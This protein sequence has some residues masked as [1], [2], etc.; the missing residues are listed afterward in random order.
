MSERDYPVGHPAA[1]DYKGEKYIP[2]RA[3]FSF[4]Y[5]EDHPARAG[6]NS[7]AVDSPDGLRAAVREQ[8]AANAAMTAKYL[9]EATVSE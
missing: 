9:A 4:D 6:R 8:H 1:S 5:E 7:S 2:K 3:P